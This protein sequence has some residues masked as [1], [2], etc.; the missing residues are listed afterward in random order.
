MENQIKCGSQ[1]RRL[2]VENSIYNG[3]DYVELITN[4][5]DSSYLPIIII[6]CFK[7]IDPVLDENNVKILGGTSI[8]NVEIKWVKRGDDL[9]SNFANFVKLENDTLKTYFGTQPENFLVIRTKDGDFSKYTLKLV[10]SQDSQNS[11]A[12][13]DPEFSQV[14]FSYKINCPS[15]FDCIQKEQCPSDVLE[16]PIINYM[17]K[18]YASFRQMILDRLTTINPAWRE[19]NPAD[20]GIMLVE[21]LCHVGDQLSYYQDAVSTEAYL[22][23]ARSRVSVRRHARLVD[24]FIHEGSNARTWVCFQI[25]DSGKSDGAIIKQKTRLITGS[26]ADIPRIDEQKFEEM[27]SDVEVFET[28]YDITLWKA[29]NRLSFYTWGDSKCCLPKGATRATLR[30]DNNQMFSNYLFRWDRFTQFKQFLVQPLDKLNPDDADQKQAIKIIV[31]LKR[32]FGIDWIQ[33][34]TISNTADQITFCYGNETISFTMDNATLMINLTINNNIAYWLLAKNNNDELRVYSLTIQ[35]GDVIVFA[36]ECSPSTGKIGDADKSHRQA[37]RLSSLTPNIDRLYDPAIPVVDI[38]WDID[39]AITFPLCLWDVPDDSGQTRPVSVVYGNTVLVDNGLTKLDSKISIG[40]TGNHVTEI[41]GSPPDTGRFT[42]HLAFAPLTYV[43]PAFDASLTGDNFVTAKGVF[44]YDRKEIIPDITI[45][46]SSGVEWRPRRDL[47]SSGK[48]SSDFVVETENDGTA[49]IRFGDGEY[50]IRPQ[51]NGIKNY[52]YAIYRIGNGKNGNVGAETICRIISDDPVTNG[53]SKI[54]NPLAAQNGTEPETLDEV[55]QYAPQAF[56][57]QQR[58]VTPADYVEILKKHHEIQDANAV[59]SWTGSW[60]TVF[61][62]ID[63]RGNIEID[64]N[65]KKEIYNYL[66]LYRLACHDIEITTPQYIPLDINIT[67]KVSGDYF[68]GNIEQTLLQT[69][70]NKIMPDGTLGFFHPD[71]F[72]FGQS[73]YLSQIYEK[74][75]KVDGIDSIISVNTFRRLGTYI[76]ETGSGFIKINPSEIVRLDN[77]PNNPENGRIKFITMCGL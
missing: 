3:I 4:P 17:A 32:N 57:V 23:T 35:I 26:D 34:S 48:D 63:R 60:Y 37:V 47:L 31:F 43:G 21:M 52:F 40:N 38:G 56:R 24:Y 13:F 30:N 39:D 53:I 62:A 72:T 22:G 74:I 10:L 29:N 2:D 27:I 28:M 67:I 1:D 61:V 75:L 5:K 46:D 41:L 8:K 65:F 49:L 12:N 42:P 71:N 25:D 45:Q 59:F 51:N 76:D 16:E 19:R 14:D 64:E 44:N 66:N 36:E 20:L 73:V 69:F 55:R 50:G 58:A 7:K 18:D 33:R 6:R 9:E 70:S 11:P 54:W 68:N 15:D 77:D